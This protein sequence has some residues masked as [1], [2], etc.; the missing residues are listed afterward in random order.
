MVF[1]LSF[2]DVSNTNYTIQHNTERSQTKGLFNTT[3][4]LQNLVNWLTVLNNNYATKQMFG[5]IYSFSEW[6]LILYHIGITG[7]YFFT[8]Y[9]NRNITPCDCYL[10]LQISV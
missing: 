8:R 5:F 3:N 9:R 4:T 2:F 1:F 6:I 7:P 10:S